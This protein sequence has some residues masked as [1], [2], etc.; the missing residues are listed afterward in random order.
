MRRLY[1][2][3]YLAVLASLALFAVSA[4]LLW[5]ASS[6]EPPSRRAQEVGALLARNALPPADAPPAE[7]QAA[8]ERLVTGLNAD[9][10]LFGADRSPLAAVGAALPPPDA[11]RGGWMRHAGGGP[12]WAVRLP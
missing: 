5:H 10:A 4:A 6:D 8:L 7:Q 1:L 3:I 2:R 12:V 11:G 9:V